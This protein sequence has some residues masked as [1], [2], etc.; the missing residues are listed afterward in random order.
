M[1]MGGASAA[2][3]TTV[4]P[5]T[6][7]KGLSVR[8]AAVGDMPVEVFSVRER[9]V[10]WRVSYHT[11]RSILGFCRCLPALGLSILGLCVM[12]M[13]V[14]TR[15]IQ[16]ETAKLAIG[17]NDESSNRCVM[18]A[19]VFEIATFVFASAIA[20]CRPARP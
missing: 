8:D 5:K 13:M 9:Y 3:P 11:T 7:K 6:R 17:Y 1:S 4:V 2:A 10:C 15:M 19:A 12:G 16:R 18:T 20:G 14:C